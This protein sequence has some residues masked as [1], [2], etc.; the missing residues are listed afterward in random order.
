MHDVTDAPWKILVVCVLLSGWKKTYTV[1]SFLTIINT[2]IEKFIKTFCFFTTTQFGQSRFFSLADD[3]NCEKNIYYQVSDN[4]AMEQFTQTKL[5][6]KQLSDF[7]KSW[8]QVCWSVHACGARCG[9]RSMAAAAKSRF[10]GCW[11]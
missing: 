8:R 1:T 5:K 4:V 7:F 11:Q 6:I 3:A 2:T 10:I 9:S